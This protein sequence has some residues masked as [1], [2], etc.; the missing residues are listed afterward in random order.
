MHDQITSDSEIGLPDILFRELEAL[1]IG[2]VKCPAIEH[3]ELDGAG[4][5]PGAR[6][7]Q[8]GRQS[9]ERLCDSRT[10]HAHIPYS[11]ENRRNP[12][13]AG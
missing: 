5:P 2:H 6:D 12:N 11:P 1:R 10:G 9:D 7:E 8:R 13:R 4:L 3:E